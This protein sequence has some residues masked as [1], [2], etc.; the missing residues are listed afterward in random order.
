MALPAQEFADLRLTQSSEPYQVF[1]LMVI[2]LH[3][4]PNLGQ[5]GPDSGVDGLNTNWHN[6]IQYG[7]LLAMRPAP[8][9][10]TELELR[11]ALRERLRGDLTE[12][13]QII[14]ELGIERGGAR[15]DL[16]VVN[17][18]LIGYEIK[19]DFDSLDR[20]ANQMHAYHRVFDE[21]SI[22]TTPQ[23]VDQVRQLLP[24]WWGILQA[25]FDETG[26]LILKV[27]QPAMANP[28]QEVLSLLSLLWRAEAAALL[29][30]HGTTKA[31]AKQ[32]RAELYEQLALL[33]DISTVR[34]WVS[35]ALRHRNTWRTGAPVRSTL[36]VDEP[37]APSDDW[38]R[39]VAKS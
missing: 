28:R 18:T 39:L 29:D 25:A 30:Q 8:H 33:A 7:I 5:G 31:K 23:F 26:T 11:S 17:G 36:P 1:L 12:D 20:L 4:C 32:N 38:L 3:E 37:F 13:A 22:V 9:R 14:E 19:S 35:H 6:G 2:P 27:V 34:D 24:P 15:I 10:T 16:A 21:L